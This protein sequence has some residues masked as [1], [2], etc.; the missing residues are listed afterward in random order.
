MSPDEQAIRQL[1]ATWIDATRA[2]DVDTVLGLMA[3]NALFL[4]PGQPPMTKAAFA[5]ASKAMAGADA[6]RIDGQSEIEEIEIAGD[7][8]FM[9]TR[10]TVTITPPGGKAKHVRAGHTLTVLKKQNGRWLLERDA[11]LLAPVP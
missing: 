10:L 4:L 11:N 1:V 9:R 8:A 7:W 5:E 2:G 3:E 6:P